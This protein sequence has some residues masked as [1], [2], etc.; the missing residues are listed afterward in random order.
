MNGSKK[1]RNTVYNEV[2]KNERRKERKKVKKLRL[3]EKKQV[4]KCR[5]NSVNGLQ[6]W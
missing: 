2:G 5:L 1:G 3:K 6:Y 4:K